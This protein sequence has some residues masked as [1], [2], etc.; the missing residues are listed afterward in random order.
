[1]KIGYARTSTA[2]QVAGLEK[3]IN[4]LNAYGCDLIFSEHVS[5]ISD[6]RI[7]FNAA[8]DSLTAGDTLV[9]TTM[10]RLV[11]RISDLGL[12]Q[13][14]LESINASLEILDLKLDTSSAIGKMTLNIIASVAQMERELMLERQRVG[15]EKARKDGKYKGRKPKLHMFKSDVL[16]YK[17]AGL[18]NT[19]IAK[20]LGI[21][22]ASVYRILKTESVSHEQSS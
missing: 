9:V 2:D 3:Q 13:T 6:D 12:I 11:R 4:D 18:K 1:M 7:E 8:I 17:E 15:I 22:I 19:E 14:K 20:L 16:R 10:S 21:G 5:A